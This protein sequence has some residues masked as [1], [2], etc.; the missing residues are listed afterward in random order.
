[1]GGPS[2]PQ[3]GAAKPSG[4][5]MPQL[6]RMYDFQFF[7]VARITELHN[8][9][10]ERCE[11]LWKRECQAKEA[12]VELSVLQPDEGEPPELSE[13]E[14][15]EKAALLEA[16]WAGWQRKEFDAFK[17]ALKLHGRADLARIAADVPDKSLE[18][19]IAYSAV[20]WARVGELAEGESLVKRVEEGEAR[21]QKSA[22]S[23]AAVA[24]K[25]AQYAN[26]ATEL[27]LSYGSSA[28]SKVY[29]EE[30]DRFILTSIPLVGYGNWEELKVAV[31]AH[32]L[33]RMD[34]FIKSRTAAELGR[35][36]DSLIRLI[37]KE[38]EDKAEQEAIKAGRPPPPKKERPESEAAAKRKAE[39]AEGKAEKLPP[40]KKAKKQAAA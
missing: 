25:L 7:N 19:V 11:W 10:K 23:R 31:R 22:D 15:A 14:A 8:K 27:R 16:G 21:L 4:P 37:E 35:R 18:E 39:K 40:A 5:K 24:A 1:M 33:F 28:K 17:K 29:T 34:W 20:F 26:P 2:G 30:E 3:R 9:E 6:A 12:G 38:L 13:A 32:W 36:A